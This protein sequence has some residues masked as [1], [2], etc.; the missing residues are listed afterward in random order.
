MISLIEGKVYST[1]ASG[2]NILTTSG[3]GYQVNFTG[4]DLCSETKIILHIYHHITDSSQSLW[5][6]KTAEE[7]KL[8]ELL[9]SVN[10]VGPSKAYPLI[11]SLGTD[12]VINSI[13]NED[14]KTLSRSPGIG[15]KMAEQIILS[16][17][18]KIG[19]FV[20]ENDGLKVQSPMF[21]PKVTLSD[22]HSQAL[23]A[24]ESLG[25]KESQ[26]LPLINKNIQLT[27]TQ[28][29]IKAVLREI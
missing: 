5:G 3:V 20:L 1:S 26:V 15:K 10:K 11:S 7:K 13:L 21:T 9:I 6:F 19:K 28:E 24:L 22:Q 2:I 17:K 16:L 8:F 12:S 4:E 27:N 25:Y 18:D 14:A 29:I 23:Q